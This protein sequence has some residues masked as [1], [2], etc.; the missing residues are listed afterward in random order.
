M[1]AAPS[2]LTKGVHQMNK[3]I[4]RG[5][6]AATCALGLG[7]AAAA[8]FVGSG[9]PT[10]ANAVTSV[11]AN[12]WPYFACVGLLNTYGVCIGPPTN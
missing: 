8:S 9:H 6:A 10:H 3:R 5:L 4:V 12:D 1:P 7:G 11:R 2:T